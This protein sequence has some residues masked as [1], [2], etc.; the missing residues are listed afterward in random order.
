MRVREKQDGH[1]YIYM[2]AKRE[3]ER[4]RDLHIDDERMCL[5]KMRQTYKETKNVVGCAIGHYA[6]ECVLTHVMEKNDSNVQ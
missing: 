4:E 2:R 6:L 5:W 1:I 3:R